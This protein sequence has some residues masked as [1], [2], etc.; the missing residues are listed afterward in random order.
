MLAVATSSQKPETL[1][2]GGFLA[3]VPWLRSGVK[4][5]HFC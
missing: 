2:K 5:F 1:P 4:Q 3:I